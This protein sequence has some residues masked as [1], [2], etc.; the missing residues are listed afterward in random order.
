MQDLRKMNLTLYSI[1]VGDTEIAE[2]NFETEFDLN[3]DST[4]LEFEGFDNEIQSQ[5]KEQIEKKFRFTMLF[6]QE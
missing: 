1:Y 2:L 4:E 3:V 5:T 6:W